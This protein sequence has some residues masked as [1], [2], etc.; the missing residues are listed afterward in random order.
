MIEYSVKSVDR[1]KFSFTNNDNLIGDLIY[2]Q[3]YNLKSYIL[4][5][6][7]LSY[8]FEPKGDSAMTIELKEGESILI[9]FK[10]NSK[11][12]ITINTKF[13]NIEKHYIFKHTG[14]FKSTYTLVDSEEEELLVI[15]TDFKWDK[16]NQDYI[17][18]ISDTFDKFKNKDII[19]LTMI[20]CINYYQYVSS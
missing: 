17:I 3:R 15:Q 6:N 12:N 16:F 9:N 14:V 4:L 1:K 5:A 19:L 8:H 7:G 20:H 10:M 13:E 11:G 2:E 18:S